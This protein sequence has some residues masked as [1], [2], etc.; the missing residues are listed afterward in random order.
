MTCSGSWPPLHRLNHLT[1]VVIPGEVTPWLFPRILARIVSLSGVT[2]RSFRAGITASPAWPWSNRRLFA[3]SGCFMRLPVHL[4]ATRRL[5]GFPARP[6]DHRR[7]TPV[8]RPTVLRPISEF[9]ASQ[10]HARARPNRTSAGCCQA[11]CC[12]IPV[13][14]LTLP[15]AE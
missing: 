12:K 7:V 14:A 4:L 9:R 15:H 5:T 1:R 3:K 8:W 10:H 11:I 6:M 2:T 13:C